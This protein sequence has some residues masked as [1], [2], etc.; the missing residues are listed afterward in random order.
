MAVYWEYTG[1]QASNAEM[2]MR[3]LVLILL[4]LCGAT[5]MAQPLVQSYTFERWDAT[6]YYPADWNLM[7]EDSYIYLNP[8]GTDDAV[9][10]WVEQMDYATT[11]VFMDWL[12]QDLSSEYT[13]EVKAPGVQ[14]F[15]EGV[16]VCFEDDEDSNI[17]AVVEIEEA[18]YGVVWGYFDGDDNPEFQDHVLNIAASFVQD[19][20]QGYT[21]RFADSGAVVHYPAGWRLDDDGAVTLS[22][23]GATVQLYDA[24]ALADWN[25]TGD[26]EAVM[27]GLLYQLDIDFNPAALVTETIA[28]RE[29]L[30]HDNP[31]DGTTV[32]V[33]FTDG[34][35]GAAHIQGADFRPVQPVIAGFNALACTIS[36][37]N[38]VNL[39]E[40]PGTDFGQVGTMSAG[41]AVPGTGQATDA[42]G[43]VWWQLD[44]AVW[45]RSDVV[46]ASDSCSSLP[47]MS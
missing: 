37:P 15:D 2:T 47:E 3:K 41:D 22:G 44:E 42:A 46:R 25:L 6:I 26:A 30:L 39:R 36:A 35:F 10:V 5:V 12:L 29:M 8:E 1:R 19:A 40:G 9:S 43:Y 24:A 27:V 4:I 18:V 23:G 33:P 28:E 20:P 32:V 31:R 45:V 11:E 38:L 16:Y 21:Y 14:T 34:T 7:A 13:I 17:A